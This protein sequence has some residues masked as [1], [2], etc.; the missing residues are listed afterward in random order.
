MMSNTDQ[1]LASALLKDRIA[2]LELMASGLLQMHEDGTL[3]KRHLVQLHTVTA[4][5]SLL[6]DGKLPSE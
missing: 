1:S 2:V 5:L 3:E 4:H 6:A